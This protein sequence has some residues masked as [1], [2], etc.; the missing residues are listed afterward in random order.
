VNSVSAKTQGLYESK[1]SHNHKILLKQSD[2]VLVGVKCY[3]EWGSDNLSLN[4]GYKR[5]FVSQQGNVCSPNVTVSTLEFPNEILNVQ[6][7]KLLKLTGDSNIYI[8]H[9]LHTL[10]GLFKKYRTLIFSA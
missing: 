10:R 9:K 5:F 6:R 2:S 1:V 4:S 7:L 8:V 3:K